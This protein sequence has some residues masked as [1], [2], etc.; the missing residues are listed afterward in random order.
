M[1]DIRYYVPTM[2][3]IEDMG[4]EIIGIEVACTD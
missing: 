1:F 3:S 2:L 4:N